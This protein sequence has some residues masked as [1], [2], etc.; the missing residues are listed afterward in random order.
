MLSLHI[1]KH[2]EEPQLSLLTIFFFFTVDGADD[3]NSDVLAIVKM[4]GLM[5]YQEANEN[6]CSHTV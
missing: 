2:L 4:L 5:Y 6:G 3:A 1:F